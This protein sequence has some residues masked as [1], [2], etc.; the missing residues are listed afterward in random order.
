VLDGAILV[1]KEHGD[2]ATWPRE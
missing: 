1:Y 2:S